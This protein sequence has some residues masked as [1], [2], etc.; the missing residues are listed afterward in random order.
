MKEGKERKGK[1]RKGKWNAR[2]IAWKLCN[3]VPVDNGGVIWGDDGL[4][5]EELW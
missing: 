3:E 2:R 5:S 1:E 4:T